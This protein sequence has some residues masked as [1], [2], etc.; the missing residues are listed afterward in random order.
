MLRALMTRDSSPGTALRRLRCD[1]GLTLRD[2]QEASLSIAKQK[3]TRKA[4]L[5]PGRLSA[6]EKDGMLPNIYRLSALAE[7]YN[8]DLRDLLRF[9]GI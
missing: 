7:I 3:R 9:Y 8:V 4:I 2:V 1:R 5:H 6:I